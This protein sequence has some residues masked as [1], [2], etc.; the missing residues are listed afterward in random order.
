MSLLNKLVEMDHEVG[1]SNSP[2]KMIAIEH[3]YWWKDRFE[4]WMKFN[5][6]RT[7]LCI[8]NGY[9]AL[10]REIDGVMSHP[11]NPLRGCTARRVNKPG[12]QSMIII[13]ASIWF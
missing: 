2:P 6:L 3:Y 10:T 4:E 9:V 11:Q 12:S 5:N 13:T 1:K 8:E 7:W